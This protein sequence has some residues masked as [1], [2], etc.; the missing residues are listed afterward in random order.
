MTAAKPR[1]L[2]PEARAAIE[3]RALEGAYDVLKLNRLLGEL[4][5]FDEANE[6]ATKKALTRMVVGIIAAVVCLIGAVA[7]YDDGLEWVWGVP[8]VAVGLAVWMGMLWKRRKNADLIND[9]RICL[10][11]ALRDLANDLDGSRRIKVKMDLA[12]PVE[13]KKT[14]EMT[15]PP[16][17]NIKVTETVYRDPWGEVRLPLV[18]GSTAVVEFEIEWR[19]LE[20]KYSNGRKV[21][22]KTKWRKQCKTSTTVL[23]GYEWDE[24]ALQARVEGKREKARLVEKEGQKGA[25]LER[26][27]MYKATGDPPQEA[28]PARELVGMLLRIYG[29]R[30]S[31]GE[32]AQ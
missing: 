12:G 21:K 9:F 13:R 8:V 30:K 10:Q 23:A 1:D 16:G 11:P 19:K 31:A 24:A 2:S 3:A 15:V 29:A 5:R 18:D 6:A 4:T 32:A 7:T 20:R 14:S 27:W 22:T 28:P 17:R 26:Y 25:R